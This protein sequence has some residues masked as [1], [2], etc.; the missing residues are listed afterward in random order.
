MLADQIG[1]WPL[2]ENG[3]GYT[4][5]IDRYMGRWKHDTMIK[6]VKVVQQ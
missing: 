1:D 5:T 6:I 4:G 2:G 3:W